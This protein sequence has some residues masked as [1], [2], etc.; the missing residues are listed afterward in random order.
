MHTQPSRPLLGSLAEA[1]RV[2]LRPKT[3]LQRAIAIVIAIKIC[4]MIALRITLSLTA[5]QEPQT[6]TGMAL[7]FFLQAASPT[8]L[9]HERA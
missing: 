1:G 7:H 8:A 4:A 2:L 3:Q 9:H 5:P 6:D